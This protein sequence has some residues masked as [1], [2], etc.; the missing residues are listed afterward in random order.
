MLMKHI[1]Q[2]F[3][4]GVIQFSINTNR[5]LMGKIKKLILEMAG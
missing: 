4:L 5:K 3:Q 1:Q 2:L